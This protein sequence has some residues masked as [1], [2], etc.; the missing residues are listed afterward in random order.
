[1]C[2]QNFKIQNGGFNMADQNKI[3]LN[4]NEIYIPGVFR[5]LI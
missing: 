2:S 5:S 4:L 3:F 1:M